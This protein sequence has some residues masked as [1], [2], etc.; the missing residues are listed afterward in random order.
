MKDIMEDISKIIIETTAE[1]KIY[2]GDL[3]LDEPVEMDR[4]T[5]IKFF[6]W[7]GIELASR[8]MI[9]YGDELTIGDELNDIRETLEWLGKNKAEKGML[10]EDPMSAC[11]V[12]WK[13][14][15]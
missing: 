5:A 4:R 15:D 2:F 14:L 11:N 9:F 8:V 13:E 10:C 6:Y 12:M 7:Y 1:D 3:S